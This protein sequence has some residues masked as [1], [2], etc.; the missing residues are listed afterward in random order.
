MA[1][2]R[3]NSANVPISTA[4]KRGLSVASLL[5][6]LGLVALSGHM[7]RVP[8]ERQALFLAV[9]AVMAFTLNS[10]AVALGVLYPNFREDN[11]GKIVSGFGGVQNVQRRCIA[12]GCVTTLTAALR[13]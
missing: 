11:P 13:R 9:A 6:T 12:H 7:L 3:A 4:R 2:T 8:W 1:S 10:L 5:I